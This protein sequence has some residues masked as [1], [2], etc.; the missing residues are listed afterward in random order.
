MWSSASAVLGA[1]ADHTAL[2]RFSEMLAGSEIPEV[3][4]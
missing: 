4:G 2:A 3:K 1:G